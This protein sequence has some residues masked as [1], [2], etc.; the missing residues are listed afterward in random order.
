MSSNSS[1]NGSVIVLDV[2]VSEVEIK[3]GLSVN[4]AAL[5]AALNEYGKLYL[6]LEPAG[7]LQLGDGNAFLT[8][9]LGELYNTL[10]KK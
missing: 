5:L 8:L 2:P 7:G 4:P 9:N 1:Q 6:A 10:N 3:P